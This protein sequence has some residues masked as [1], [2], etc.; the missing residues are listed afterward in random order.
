VNIGGVNHIRTISPNNHPVYENFTGGII[1]NSN[2]QNDG[3]LLSNRL[4]KK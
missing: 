3:V 4:P 1:E 2:F